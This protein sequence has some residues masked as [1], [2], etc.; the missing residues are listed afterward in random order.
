LVLGGRGGGGGGFSLL[1]G[2]VGAEG[3]EE[4][5]EEGALGW[6]CVVHEESSVFSSR[7]ESGRIGEE[8]EEAFE[9]EASGE[10]GLR[11][12][13]RTDKASEGTTV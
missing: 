8:E 13:S 3:G 11:G 2:A 4:V 10:L 5:G 6:H 1:D 12:G 9:E 7:D